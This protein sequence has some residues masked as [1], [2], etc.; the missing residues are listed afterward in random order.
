MFRAEKRARQVDSDGEVPVFEAHLW[1][2]RGRA[3]DSGV[4][5]QDVDLTE[6]FHGSRNHP[7]DTRFISHIREHS[8]R[9]TSRFAN[10]GLD[11][12]DLLSGWTRYHDGSAFLSEPQGDS[13]SY[14]A[15]AA[16]YDC[17]FALKLHPYLLTSRL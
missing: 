6:F 2:E 4:V 17:D 15:A 8:E 13:A 3:G 7:L 12:R 1:N 14:S 16:G 11:A 5:N 9:S 10:L